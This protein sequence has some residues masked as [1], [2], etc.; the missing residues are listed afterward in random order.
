MAIIEMIPPEYWAQM[1]EELNALDPSELAQLAPPS[2]TDTATPKRRETPGER[3]ARIAAEYDEAIRRKQE[4][5]EKERAATYRQSPKAKQRA[6]ERYKAKRDA[7]TTPR[8][9]PGR[10]RAPTDGLTSEQLKKM[11]QNREAS[12]RYR[13]SMRKFQNHLKNAQK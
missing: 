11:E 7:D 3:S 12:A 4:Q 9:P 10:P 2:E 13:E 8:R 6:A 1:R 5:S